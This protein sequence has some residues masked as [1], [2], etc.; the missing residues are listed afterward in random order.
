MGDVVVEETLEVVEG[1]VLRDGGEDRRGR[2]GGVERDAATKARARGVDVLVRH[3]DG[4]GGRSGRRGV[5]DGRRNK[6]HWPGGE[7]GGS[8]DGPSEPRNNSNPS[9]YYIEKSG[10]ADGDQGIGRA[11]TPDAISNS[12]QSCDAHSTAFHPTKSNS[13]HQPVPSCPVLIRHPPHPSSASFPSTLYAVPPRVWQVQA[14]LW[15]R[16]TSIFLFLTAA[17]VRCGG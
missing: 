14:A 17:L 7:H 4:D 9:S 11:D 6:L 2:G 15:T 12:T 8:G 1:A 10:P 3:W 13:V 5:R 16:V